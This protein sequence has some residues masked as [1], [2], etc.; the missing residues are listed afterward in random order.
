[1]TDDDDVNYEEDADEEGVD[2]DSIAAADDVDEDIDDELEEDPTVKIGPPIGKKGRVGGSSQVA[3]PSK[4]S[5]L[6]SS[7][8]P[9]SP[10]KVTTKTKT[11]Q[12]RQGNSPK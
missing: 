11:K 10:K 8:K 12:Q 3:G 4:L 9:P 1:V 7:S 2:G 6:D 5:S